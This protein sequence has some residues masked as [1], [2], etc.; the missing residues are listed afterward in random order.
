MCPL[1]TVKFID[2]IVRC[3]TGGKPYITG[4]IKS[5]LFKRVASGTGWKYI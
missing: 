4:I 3:L 5:H 2:P 1:G